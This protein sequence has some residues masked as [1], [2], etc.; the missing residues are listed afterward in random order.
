M[1]GIIHDNEADKAIKCVQGQAVAPERE[2]WDTTMEYLVS[3]GFMLF[4]E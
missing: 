3:L 2:D 4:F 1:E